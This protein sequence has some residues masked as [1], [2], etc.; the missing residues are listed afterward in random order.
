MIKID[1]KSYVD[2][3]YEKLKSYVET[4]SKDEDK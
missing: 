4:L 3:E 2:A 1:V